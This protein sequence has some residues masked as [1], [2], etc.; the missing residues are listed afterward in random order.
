M[1]TVWIIIMLASI[2]TLTFIDPSAVMD[3]LVTGATDS[4]SLALNLVALYS[5][6]LGLFEL[7]DKI[8][9]SD[10]LAHFLRP[11]VRFLFRGENYE[12]EKYISMNMSANLLGIG[13]AATPMGMGAIKNMKLHATAPHKAT[14]NMIMFIVISAT[15]LQ[16]F[17]STVISMRA[18]AGSAD[19]ADFLFPCIVATIL[20]TVIGII[21]V[22]LI[23]KVVKN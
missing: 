17:P 7:L 1:N 12:C 10:K 19:S 5:V 16:L 3:G 13:N 6:W 15:S 22:K 23:G 4:V 9:A 14:I 18:V 20:S 11:L 2:T 21:F 8:G